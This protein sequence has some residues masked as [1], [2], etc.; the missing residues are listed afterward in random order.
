MSYCT[1]N[2]IDNLELLAF[3]KLN[4][5][6]QFFES[7]NLKTNFTKSNFIHFQ[8]GRRNINSKPIVMID[9]H[10]L[11]EVTHTKFLGI[12]I[13]NNLSW[14]SHINYI[15]SKI[16]SSIFLLRYLVLHCKPDVLR[17]AYFGLINS[18][19]NYGL[20]VWG[21]CSEYKLIRI[22]ILQKISIRIMAKL[23]FSDSCRGVFK[24]LEILNLPKPST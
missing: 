24:K 13:D 9:E 22:F 15:S 17:M 3:E 5:C 20:M 2:S 14:D 6:T 7:L 16:S 23:V 19:M 18:Y 10:I 21:S 8:L 1:S 4:V 12:Y 11:E